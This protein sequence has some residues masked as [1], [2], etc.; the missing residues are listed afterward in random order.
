[1][2]AV[3][4]RARLCI[5]LLALVVLTTLGIAVLLSTAG[6]ANADH[7]PNHQHDHDPKGEIVIKRPWARTSPPRAKDG[8]VYMDIENS[9]HTDNALVRVSVPTSVARKAELHETTKDSRGI[10]QMSKVAE[11][12][13]AAESTTKLEPGGFHIML[14]GL[15][16]PLK[17]GTKIPLTLEFTAGHTMK[18]EAIAKA[19]GASGNSGGHH[20]HGT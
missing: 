3:T 4:E 7:D 10:V 17:A 15:R 9:A 20:E 6:P 13:L 1:M 12:T 8:A 16:K 2:I 18:V 14:I 19:R 11:I 5:R